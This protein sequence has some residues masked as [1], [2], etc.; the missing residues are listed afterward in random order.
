M[1][2]NSNHWWLPATGFVNWLKGERLYVPLNINSDTFF[3][4]S[5]LKAKTWDSVFQKNLYCK[6]VVPWLQKSSLPR[7]EMF[8]KNFK[9]YSPFLW[10]GFHCLK[11]TEPLQGD[12]LLFTTK[13]PEISG[14]QLINLWRMNGWVNLGA[15]QWFWTQN[16]W[17]GNLA[18]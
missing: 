17:I 8:I 9:L 3:G 11:A 16:P 1:S 18:P 10:A 4:K 5:P 2:S 12:N 6:F 7:Y 14:A 15:T 13:C